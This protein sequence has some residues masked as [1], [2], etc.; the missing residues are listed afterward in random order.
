MLGITNNIY[1]G[2]PIPDENN[3]QTILDVNK[4]RWLRC[5][6]I[7]LRQIRLLIKHAELITNTKLTAL[8]PDEAATLYK[9]INKLRS[10][11]NKTKML[12]F[13][14]G[15]IYCGA[16]LKKFEM[17]EIET[18]IRCFEKET[19][20][21]LQLECPYTQEIW[22]ALGVDFRQANNAIGIQMSRED[23]V[24]HAD[25]LSS[26]VFRK[27]TLPPNTLIEL[28]YL[29]YSEGICKNYKVKELA[30]TRLDNHN[31]TGN[32]NKHHLRHQSS[33]LNQP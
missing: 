12:R 9:N 20:K 17:S 4:G 31:L 6:T 28:T 8:A 1:A 14:H 3:Y 27:S 10:T 18:C 5:S 2:M 26:I 15:D 23:V 16:R 13:I 33:E 32:G 19:I 22:R 11:Q 29:K 30:K 21:H 25:L 7:T 24:I